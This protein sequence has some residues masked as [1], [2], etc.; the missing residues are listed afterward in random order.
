MDGGK[1]MT[2]KR[3]YITE[4]VNIVKEAMGESNSKFDEEELIN[5]IKS[6]ITDEQLE[7]LNVPFVLY[8]YSV[9]GKCKV[10]LNNVYL[11]VF[12]IDKIPWYRGMI[13]DMII[14][15]GYS[16]KECCD[17]FRDD[18]IN[19]NISKG[20]KRAKLAKKIAGFVDEADELGYEIKLTR[21]KV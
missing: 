5:Q 13:D 1:K 9:E 3:D 20:M 19:Q 15:E 11:G 18:Y 7:Y 2:H 21:K 14:D 16:L 8:K 4:R 6:K 10:T 12:E 17:L